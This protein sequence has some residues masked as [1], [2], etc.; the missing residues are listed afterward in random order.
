MPTNIGLTVSIFPGVWLTIRE[1]SGRAQ[2]ALGDWEKAREDLVAAAN[3]QPKNVGIQIEIKN[4]D[5]K[6][7]QFEEKE[8]RQAAAMFA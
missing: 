8:R 5:K 3:I 7:K 1:L 2:V 4:L 6:V